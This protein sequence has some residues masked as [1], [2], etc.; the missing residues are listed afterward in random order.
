MGGSAAPARRQPE[1]GREWVDKYLA[2]TDR[3]GSAGFAEALGHALFDASYRMMKDERAVQI[4]AVVAMLASVGGYFCILPVLNAL[5]E[6]GMAPA[7]IGMLT[8]Q[9]ADGATYHFGDAP[10][11]LLCEHQLS[12]VSLVFGAAQEHGGKVS[13]ELIHAEMSHVASLVG[14][15]DFM[16]LDLPATITVDSPRNWLKVALPFV[17]KAIA[18]AFVTDLRRQGMPEA[19][20]VGAEPPLFMLHRIV[21]FALQQAIDVGH[22]ALD[23][24]TLARIALQCAVRTAKLDPAALA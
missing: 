20:L 24:T 19:M 21:G 9:G 2:Q 7:D 10:N 22:Q 13:M 16:T 23:A 5:K 4:E 11:R 6:A 3:P 8:I 15:P 14:S 18:D 12:V 1:D 17:R